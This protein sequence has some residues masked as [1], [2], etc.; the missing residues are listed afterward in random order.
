MACGLLGLALLALAGTA[1]GADQLWVRKPRSRSA[2]VIDSSSLAALCMRHDLRLGEME[3]VAA[4]KRRNCKGW[5]CGPVEAEEEE[6]QEEE[7]LNLDADQAVAADIFGPEAT[8]IGN[9]GVPRTNTNRAAAAAAPP[10]TVAEPDDDDDDDDD[11][12]AEVVTVSA[13]DD[14]D[15]DDGATA[16]RAAAVRAD[17]GAGA[18]VGFG[19][20]LLGLLRSGQALSVLISPA[21]TLALAVLPKKI[22]GDLQLARTLFYI[23]ALVFFGSTF[24]AQISIQ[25]LPDD[26]DDEATCVR[27]STPP[28]PGAAMAAALGGSNAAAAEPEEQVLSRREY[29]AGELS[30][31]RTAVLSGAALNV[32]LSFVMKQKGNVAG[33]R[34]HFGAARPMY[35]GRRCGSA[36]EELARSLPAC[37]ALPLSR[38]ALPLSSARTQMHVCVRALCR[39][40]WLAGWLAL[41]RVLDEDTTLQS[42][43]RKAQM[44]IARRMLSDRTQREASKTSSERVSERASDGARKEQG[45]PKER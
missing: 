23:Y 36:R 17:A 18:S 27:V 8:V 6:E 37:S 40:R 25:N 10:P 43:H 15:D 20:G 22:T 26:A 7:S 19:A 34:T 38:L 28:S 12:E 4:G 39:S 3:Q 29:D 21:V 45:A 14:D 24:L 9:D 1:S 5:E 32:G 41:A 2:F 33:T 13:G 42:M 30:K 44:L 16:S 31:L 35:W 11:D